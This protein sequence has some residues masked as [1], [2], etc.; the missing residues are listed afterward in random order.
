M[1]KT[2]IVHVDNAAASASRVATASRLACAYDAHLVGAAMTGLSPYIFP[3]DGFAPG[4]PSVTF[5]VEQLR[6]EADRALDQ[7]EV[8]ARQS[9]VRSHARRRIDDE[10]SAG[11]G[12]QSRYCDLLVIS[13]AGA[14]PGLPHVRPDFPESVLLNCARPVLILPAAGCPVPPGRR[15]VVAWNG[16]ADA[17]RAITSALGLL[18][19]AEHVSL[20]VFE[21]G[22][23]ATLGEDKG[24]NMGAYLRRHGIDASIT[25]ADSASSELGQSLL[26]FAGTQGADLIVMGAYGHARLREILL[27]GATR[28]VLRSSTIALWMT[29]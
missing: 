2:I 9:G 24:V 14:D 16:S 17:V 20:V 23:H 25:V 12:M 29:H 18:Q 13:Q 22:G 8:Q 15:A 3:V 5:P 26:T 27:G 19:R 1:Y 10:A 21:S 6:Q 28:T 4:L 7:F 11:L